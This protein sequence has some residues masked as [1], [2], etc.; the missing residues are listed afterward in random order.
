MAIIQSP[1]PPVKHSPGGRKLIT[2]EDIAPDVKFSNASSTAEKIL[3]VFHFAR[4]TKN[5]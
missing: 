2:V 1:R 5:R 4:R 3:E